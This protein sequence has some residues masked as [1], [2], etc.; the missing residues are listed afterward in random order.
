MVRSFPKQ[1]DHLLRLTTAIYKYSKDLSKGPKLEREQTDLVELVK[2]L[3]NEFKRGP[4]QIPIRIEINSQLDRIPVLI[5]TLQMRQALNSLLINAAEACEELLHG[6]IKVELKPATLLNSHTQIFISDNG[7]G[8]SPEI[9][10]I[11]FDPFVSYGKEN[12]IGLGLTLSKRVIEA[13]GGKIQLLNREIGA[14]FCVSI[15]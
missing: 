11:L 3:V 6:E 7:H 8:I 14:G 2:L 12:G 9:R 10:E 15:P 4:L 1:A 13:H 5:D